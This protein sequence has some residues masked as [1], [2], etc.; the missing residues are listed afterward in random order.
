MTRFMTL[1]LAIALPAPVAAAAQPSASITVNCAGS[2]AAAASREVPNFHGTWDFVM[3]V[4]GTPNFGLL[5]I[6]F[7]GNAYAGSLGLSLT[8]PVVVRDITLT[9][10]RFRLVTA[11]PAGD[12][13]FDGTL[14]PKGD[15]MCGTIT[16]HD[17]RTFPAVAQK[18]PSTYQSTPQSQRSSTR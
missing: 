14:S 1:A 12:V 6:G 10:D 9:G 8:A 15:R 18:R 7:V 17:G 16:Y 13:V 4:A 3:D 5:S 2:G 11:S